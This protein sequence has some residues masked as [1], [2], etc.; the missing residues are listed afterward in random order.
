MTPVTFGPQ[1][2]A[3]VRNVGSIAGRNANHA[4]PLRFDRQV[5]IGAT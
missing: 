4:Q 3:T 2:R 1:L 5:K